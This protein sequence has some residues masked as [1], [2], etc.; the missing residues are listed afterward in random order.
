VFFFFS[1]I[2]VRKEYFNNKLKF[3]CVISWFN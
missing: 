2:K 1:K 3:I